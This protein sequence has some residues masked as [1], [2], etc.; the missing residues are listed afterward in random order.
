MA[1]VAAEALRKQIVA[2]DAE[3]WLSENAAALDAKAQQVA[4]EGLWC[5]EH[6]LF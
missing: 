5:D 6:R 4:A 2:H 1:A 3:A